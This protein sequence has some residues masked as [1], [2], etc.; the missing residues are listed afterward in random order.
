MEE[1]ELSARKHCCNQYHSKIV[2]AFSSNHNPQSQGQRME[3]TP[4]NKSKIIKAQFCAPDSSKNLSH[5]SHWPHPPWI[6]GLGF[7]RRWKKNQRDEECSKHW[8]SVTPS[9]NKN[10][11]SRR[12][13]GLWFHPARGQSAAPS[14][15]GREKM[16]EWKSRVTLWGFGALTL[17]RQVLGWTLRQL[18]EL[19]EKWESLSF[20]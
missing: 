1:N 16:S 3:H 13:A 2:L 9:P 7:A 6:W 10:I 5:W 12:R 14:V 20:P 17:I 18:A 11:N 4:K 15:P 19:Q 8:R